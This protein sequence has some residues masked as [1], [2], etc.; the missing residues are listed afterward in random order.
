MSTNYNE[1]VVRGDTNHT[2]AVRGGGTNYTEAVGEETTI[3][4]KRWEEGT[5]ITLKQWGED[6][7]YTEA[8]GGGAPIT[9]KRWGEG[10]PIT[11]GEDNG[12]P[13]WPP[14][15]ETRGCNT[16]S[17]GREV[18]LDERKQVSSHIIM[19]YIDR[20]NHRSYIVFV[21]TGRS[22]NYNGIII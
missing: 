19:V 4:L 22:R 17:I 12:I 6:A 8:V 2:E 11:I 13:P 20:N 3:T 16:V 14:L 7:N 1:T 15:L 10:A 18:C 5:L 21:P 9:M